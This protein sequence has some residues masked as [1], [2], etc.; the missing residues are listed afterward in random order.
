MPATCKHIT[1]IVAQHA[2]E[3]AFLWSHRC[4]LVHMPHIGLSQ[5]A[6]HDDRL[7]AHIDGLRVAGDRGWELCEV[8]LEVGEPGEMFAAM[9][10]AAEEKNAAKMDK[11]FALAESVPAM[12]TGLIAAFGWI[13]AQFLQGTIGGFLAS[14]SSFRRRVGIACCAMHRV[15]PHEALVAAIKDSDEVLRAQAL[16]AIGELGRRDLM[17][18]CEQHLRDEDVSCRFYAASSTALLG[19]H[20][21]AI[22]ALQPFLPATG[23]FKNKAMQLALKIMPLTEAHQTLK[24]LAANNPLDKR[25]LIKGAGIAGDPFY[26]PWLIKEMEIPAFARLAGESIGFITGVDLAKLDLD[27]KPPENFESGPNDDP[28]D[29]NVAMDE[30]ENLPWPDPE[31]IQAW[32]NTNQH[33]FQSGIRHFMGEPVNIEHCKKA[34]RDGFQRQRVAA[35]L[36]LSLLQPGM[37]LFPTSAPAWRQQR[38]LAKIG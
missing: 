7:A 13:S 17:P 35:A 1:P 9:L 30:D 3:T 36:Y 32:W 16:R 15:D 23:P 37:P 4:V 22:D 24:T 34:L 27:R 20:K 33:R 14:T 10:I 26:V 31:K 29:A 21:I 25:T 2:E 8:Q 5:L 12:Q 6:K 38:W 18:V 19:N 28:A 11:L